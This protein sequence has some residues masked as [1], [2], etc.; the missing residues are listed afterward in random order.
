MSSTSAADTTSE[1]TSA[2][3]RLSRPPTSAAG[4]ALRP[5]TT[6]R[7]FEAGIAGDQHPGHAAGKGGKPPG[8]RV[9]AVQADAALRRKERVLAGGAH[10]DAPAR[11][12]QEGEEGAVGQRRGEY[13]R[14]AD[15]RDARA[16][17]GK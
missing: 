7:S 2:P 17:D 16:A 3:A 13:E 1:P 10:A 11:A 12:A 6:Q 4:N 5:M 15:C 14:K 8:E 9:N